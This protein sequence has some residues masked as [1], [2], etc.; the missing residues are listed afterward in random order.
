MTKGQADRPAK[1][2]AG[3]RPKE[4]PEANPVRPE[5]AVKIQLQNVRT[6]GAADWSAI[7]ELWRG[8]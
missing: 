3:K 7:E 5:H 6:Y 1:K 2:R 8:L 4:R